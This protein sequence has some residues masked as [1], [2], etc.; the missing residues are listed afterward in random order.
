MPDKIFP[1]QTA[2]SCQLKWT[3][4]TLHLY[5]GETNSCHRVNTSKIDVENFARFHNTPKKLSD[6][7]LM[8]DGLWPTGGCEYCANIEAV[9]GKSDRMFQKEIPNLTPP[10]LDTD[11]TAIEVT[12]RIVE[13]YLDNICNMSCIYCEDKYSSR[14]QHENKVHGPFKQGDIEIKN[15]A[16]K[17]DDFEKL[18]TN[19]WQWMDQHY[20]DLR[21]LHVLGGEPFFQ[22]SFETCMN[23]LETHMNPE[24]EFNVVSNLKLSLSK[25]ENFLDRIKHLL[26]ERRIKR[27]DITCSIDCWGDEQEYIRTGINMEDWQRN[28]EYLVA[29]KWIK[30]N[31]NQ[32]ITGLGMKS[33]PDL[34]R[35]INKHR[36][37]REIGHYFMA[38]ITKPYLNPGA[39][40]SGFF[41]EEFKQILAEMPNDTWQHQHAYSM[42][43]GL[44]LEFNSHKRDYGQLKNLEIYLNEID[45]RR[46]MNWK[47]TFPWLIKEL[48]YVV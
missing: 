21:R 39:F 47:K 13:V 19:F 1:I 30:V 48:N 40:G 35:Y 17:T 27:F 7:R 5:T 20:T 2:T 10:E 4:S 45:R 43:Q 12:P 6:R 44:Q 25:L 16:K 38:C 18:S 24:L 26:K 31:I 22:Q 14:I 41:D 34:I 28:F 8:L 9:G 23:F 11:P 46:N 33:M 37:H 29:Q 42:M 32:T 15:L 36:Q 3:W